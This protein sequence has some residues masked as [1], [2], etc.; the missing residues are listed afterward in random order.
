MK[1][2][3]TFESHSVDSF[4]KSYSEMYDLAKGQEYE[5]FIQLSEEL[6]GKYNILYRGTYNDYI[7]LSECS[8][9]FMADFLTHAEHYGEYVDGLIYEEKDLLWFDDNTFDTLK[10]YNSFDK[11]ELENIYKYFFDNYLLDDAMDQHQY[12]S[13]KVIDFVFTFLTSEKKYS[14]IQRK[15]ANDF[16]I[17]VML[18]YAKSKNKNIIGFT[19]GSFEFMGGADEF[20]VANVSKHITLK[21]IWN[22]VN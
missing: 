22:D 19:G 18:H 7:K 11:T 17:P 16:L 4:A 5:E 6:S 2:I 21:D 14:T 10:R 13:D 8:N 3:K 20:V 9:V 12:D 15:K 1:Y